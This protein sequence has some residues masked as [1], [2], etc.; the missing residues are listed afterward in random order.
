MDLLRDLEQVSHDIDRLFK[1]LERPDIRE[2]GAGPLLQQLRASIEMNLA[3][4]RKV[5]PQALAELEALEQETAALQT[6]TARNQIEVH[7]LLEQFRNPPP[8][9]PPPAPISVEAGRAVASDL[10]RHY[11]APKPAVARPATT[12][13][14]VAALGSIDFQSSESSVDADSR[15][16]QAPPRL[17]GSVPRKTQTPN[18][19]EGTIDS[20]DFSQDE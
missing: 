15:P 8:P 4:A 3:E 5:A 18:R 14:D 6:E 2:Q 12:A 10:L 20:G 19:G 11:A 17:P 7:K 1:V 13:A 16:L 9:P